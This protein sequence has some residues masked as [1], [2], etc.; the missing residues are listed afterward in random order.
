MR[1]EV[2]KRPPP[3]I[4]LRWLQKQ[5]KRQRGI[6]PIFRLKMEMNGPLG[7]TLDQIKPG[8]GYTRSNTILVAAAANALKGNRTMRETRALLRKIAKHYAA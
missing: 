4:T 1:C 5:W 8:K 6:C 2:R 3:Q 7:V